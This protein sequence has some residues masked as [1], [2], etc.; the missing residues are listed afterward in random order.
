ME[1]GV[2]IM[3]LICIVLAQGENAYAFTLEEPQYALVHQESD[4]EVR[5]YREMTWMSASPFQE[6]SFEK[7]T[8]QGFHRLFQFIEG[9]NMNFSRIPMTA[10]VLTSIVPGAGPFG[11]S[12]YIVRF[13]L[14]TKFQDSPPVPLKAL[15]LY[16][17][18]WEGHCVAVRK[19]SGF[20]K[21]ENI[22]K[23][24]AKLAASLS[25]SPWTDLSFKGGENYAYSI[26]QYDSPFKIFGRLNEVWVNV[27]GSSEQCQPSLT[28][29]KSVS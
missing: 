3:L 25:D 26:A 7:A 13:Y 8:L 1:L 11:S 17:D 2:W 15:N 10:P 24:A 20:A 12:G 9:A 16:P 19:F 29:L 23:E 5:L 22:V 21:D 18:H 6:V 27:T 14:P 28:L 4:F